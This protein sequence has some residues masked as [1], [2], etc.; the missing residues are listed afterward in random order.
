MNS[1]SKNCYHCG[2]AKGE[3]APYQR[4]LA[5]QT[6]SF[7]CAGCQ[8]IAQTIHDQGLYAFYAHRSG[9]GDKPIETQTDSTTPERLQ[10]FDDPA[11]VAR[12]TRELGE[13]VREVTL[14]LDKTRY[15]ACVWLNEQLLRR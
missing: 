14:H 10:V 4:V 2:S 15:A 13:D 9:L 8:A 11:L 6:R 3:A 5:G 1:A 12:F 7:Y